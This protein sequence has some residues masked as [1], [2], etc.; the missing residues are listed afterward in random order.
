MSITANGLTLTIGGHDLIRGVDLTT[1]PGEM[2]AIV[3]PNGAGKSTLLRL[4]GGLT[5]AT[6]GSVT[7]DGHEL[8]GL[9]VLELAR[10]RSYLGPELP[11]GLDFTVRD[12]V[13]M[14]RHPWQSGRVGSEEATEI[15]L[16]ALDLVNLADRPHSQLST[17]EARRTQIA[18]VLAQGSPLLLL[19]EPTSGLDLAHTELVI[20]RLALEARADRTVITVLHDLN[21]AAVAASR[22]VAM[23]DGEVVADG[24]AGEVLTES[25]LTDLYRHP[26]RVIDHPH[27]PGVLILPMPRDD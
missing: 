9:P 3:G 2:I 5:S 13:R 22:V 21:D 8:S 20:H 15:A 26:V 24:P 27:R 6:A 23:S 10:K 4:L 25:L 14:G 11:T 12:V 17:G 1:V 16:A 7:L 19:D 18:R